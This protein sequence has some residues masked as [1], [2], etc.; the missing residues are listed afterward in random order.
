[1]QDLGRPAWHSSGVPLS[2]ATDVLSHRIANTLVGTDDSATTLEAAGGGWK[3][4]VEQGG[5]AAH[6]GA[7]GTLWVDGVEA[8]PGRTLWLPTGAI[9]HIRATAAGN[10]SYLATA[11][12]WAVPEVLGSRSTCLAAGFGG[13][14]GR[15][16]RAG[17]V[18]HSDETI[19][20]KPPDSNLNLN[21]QF[22]QSRWYA[23]LPH[24][25]GKNIIRILPGPEQ[26]WWSEEQ[27]QVFFEKPF[28]ITPQRDRMGIRL[29][30]AASADLR[31]DGDITSAMLSTAVASGTIQV[32]PDGCPIVLLADAQTTGGYPRIGQVAA[33]DLPVLAQAPPGQSIYFRQISE[34]EAE[35]RLREQQQWVQ[36]LRLGMNLWE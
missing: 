32:P 20:F 30:P 33:A 3:A 4:Q 9:L 1:M 24:R 26:G 12:G 19:N 10:F 17:D 8:K 11:G 5:W 22:W 23:A 35:Q 18:L 2:G 13:L 15:P 34:E 14:D 6:F 36:R 28:Q 7:G 21:G 27:R 29:L 16:L 31:L 25:A